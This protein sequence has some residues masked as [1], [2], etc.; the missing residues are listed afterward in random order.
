MSLSPEILDLLKTVP[1]F[2][3]LP[4]EVLSQHFERASRLTLA[5]GETLLSPGDVNENIYIILSGRLRENS[6]RSNSEPIAMFGEG[7]SVGV[8]T[9][10][11]G[12]KATDYF[13]ADTDCELL[14]IDL[15][16]IWS[17]V[18]S[19]HHAALNL[20]DILSTPA[21]MRKRSNHDVELQQGYAGLERVD[22]LTGLYNARWISQIFER[23][24]RRLAIIHEP[25]IL[26]MVSVDQFD[27]YNQC[28]GLLGGDQALRTIAQIILLCLRPDD[29]S[30]RYN[31]PVFAVYMSRTTLEQGMIAGQR[32]LL[33]ASQAEVVTPGGDVLPHVT[34]SIG[35]AEIQEG[36][37][38]PQIFDKA[39]EA[40]KHAMA[41][42]GNC[43]RS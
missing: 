17:L 4:N 38:M 5:A 3:G 26:M 22:E 8:T 34:I 19:S 10:L 16:T 43:I 1:L 6:D 18:K 28:H 12:N 15:A 37:S 9:I 24:I 2:S 25:S 23:Q 30:G 40:L 36:S 20:L 31:G 42:G 32:L 27:H 35:I 7:D 21:P 29:H 41:A 11:N 33:Q 39:G 14:C 13:F